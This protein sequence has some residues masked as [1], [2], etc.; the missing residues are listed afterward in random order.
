MFLIGET[1][2]K[3]LQKVKLFILILFRLEM[4]YISSKINDLNS[5]VFSTSVFLERITKQ[6]VTETGSF[7]PFQW[8]P[9]KA[10]QIFAALLRKKI[11]MALGLWTAEQVRC[12]GRVQWSVLARMQTCLNLMWCMKWWQTT[13][14]CTYENTKESSILTANWQS[15]K[16]HTDDIRTYH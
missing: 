12:N 13:A 16:T 5:Q 3:Q 14:T 7:T 1:I 2:T 11:V 15:L 10:I 9:Y 6:E 8:F 4:L